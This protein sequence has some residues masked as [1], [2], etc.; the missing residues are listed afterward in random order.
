MPLQ[1]TPERL[2]SKIVSANALASSPLRPKTTGVSVNKRMKEIDV[3]EELNDFG[4]QGLKVTEDELATLV[5]DL[6]LDGD[7]AQGL[8]KGL[9]SGV[10]NEERNPAKNFSTAVNKDKQVVN[11][12]DTKSEEVLKAVKEVLVEE[13]TSTTNTVTT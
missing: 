2:R 8:L 13:K 5:S 12:T 6:G 7:L 9:G 3:G 4:L 1:M 10:A 11:S